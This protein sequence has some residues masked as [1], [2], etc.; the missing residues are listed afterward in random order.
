M[1]SIN[2]GNQN[3]N[4]SFFDE[5]RQEDWARKDNYITP[6]GIYSGGYL[7]VSGSDFLLSPFKVEI[8]D[9]NIQVSIGTNSDAVISDATLDSG[10]LSA[11]KYIVLRYGYVYDP[12][13]WLEVHSVSTPLTNDIVVGKISGVG[14][15]VSYSERTEPNT[16]D[17]RLKVIPA[18][19]LYVRLQ[20][21]M[22]QTATGYV[23]VSNKLVGPFS[24]PPVPSSRKDLVYIDSSGVP[25]ILQ[26]A[27]S[28]S[29]FVAPAYNG[30][31]VLA[32]VLVSN[33]VTTLPA[34]VIRDVRTSLVANYVPPV[35]VEVDAVGVT[36]TKD[37]LGNPLLVNTVYKAT[38]SGAISAIGSGAI[39]TIS[40]KYGSTASTSLYKDRSGSQ[41][42]YA[43]VHGH[44]RKDNYV[45]LESDIPSD[46]INWTP[47]GGTGQLVKQ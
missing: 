45:K 24:T 43:N 30:R 17:Y 23:K 11:N 7:T 13:N 41:W 46:L 6:R 15:T 32:E 3:V 19:G 26:G 28:I 37:S 21:G 29:P 44:I 40:I 34:S 35:Q 18:S 14:G 31:L 16:L 47:L 2:H 38:G 33:G 25:Q 4:Y 8:G 39:G 5:L 20:G 1:G 27:A 42:G 22:I 9:G 10:T 36:T 12:L